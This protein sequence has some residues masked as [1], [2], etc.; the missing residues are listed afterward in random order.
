MKE[1]LA[2]TPG[3]QVEY[4]SRVLLPNRRFEEYLAAMK[5]VFHEDVHYIDPVH[6]FRG[7]D[8]GCGPSSLGEELNME[9]NS[10]SCD[11]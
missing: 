2:A 5:Q 1:V 8:I 7:R 10:T 3:K 11:C 9:M 6:E 4:A